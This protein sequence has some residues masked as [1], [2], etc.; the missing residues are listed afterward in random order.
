MLLWD[1]SPQPR[2][3][4]SQCT[5]YPMGYQVIKFVTEPGRFFVYIRGLRCGHLPPLPYTYYYHHDVRQVAY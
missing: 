4:L 1:I 2:T 3:E 5:G